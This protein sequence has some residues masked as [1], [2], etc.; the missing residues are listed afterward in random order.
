MRR[1]LMIVGFCAMV[2]GGCS[3]L[4]KKF[5]LEN[6]NPIEQSIEGIIKQKTGLGVDLTP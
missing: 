3:Y 2:F 1:L 4:N 5:G 6:D